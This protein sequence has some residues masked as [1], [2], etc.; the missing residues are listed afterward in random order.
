MSTNTLP[1]VASTRAGALALKDDELIR[2]MQSSL[3]S[4]ATVDSIK[5][6]IGYCTAA[7]LDPMQK[8]VHIVPMNV[9]K[10]GTDVKEWRDVI[11]P[12]IGL[13]RT[14]AARSGEYLGKTEPV[15]GPDIEWKSPNGQVLL[16]YPQWCRVTV[17][18]L[19]GGHVAE[20]SAT[21]L[22]IENYATASSS[23]DAPNAMWKR[24]PYG[25]LAKVAEAQ[26]LRQAFPE[27]IG[28]APT[29]DE[30]N[31]GAAADFEA[32]PQ[33]AKAKPAR[34]A[35]DALDQF[36]G[37]DSGAEDA[38][39]AMPAAAAQELEKGRWMSAWK[40]LSATMP[41]SSQPVRVALA[42]KYR[43]SLLKQVA[44]HS[45]A[46]NDRVNELLTTCQIEKNWS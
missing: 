4:G 21:E 38:L 14:Q 11:M 24:R 3:Y 1:A 9:K 17:R 28:A 39:P 2:V 29:E 22:W 26:A 44:T 18:R 25:Q 35:A 23:T 30:F 19:V 12:G 37:A 27:L 8:P 16:I 36:A 34:T 31:P 40:W 41:E 45:Q 15:F 20:F 42:I 46:Y 13:Y 43:D 32:P 33:P 10:P 7:G 5:M 6:V